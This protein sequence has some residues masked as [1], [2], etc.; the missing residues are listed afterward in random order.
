MNNRNG[1]R[2]TG[3]LLLRVMKKTAVVM[4]ILG[5]VIF[6][7]AGSLRYWNGWLYIGSLLFLMIPAMIYMCRHNPQ[8]I[9]KR[10]SINE[11]EKE[12]KVFV[13]LSVL[14]CFAS[15]AVPGL[16]Y[17]FG[18]S[19]VPFWLVM[20]SLLI[21]ISAYGMFFIVMQQNRY[22]SRVIEIQDN[23]TLIDTGLYSVIRH[24]MYS[25][26][27]LLYGVSPLVMGSY[28]A[29]I[30]LSFLPPL[31]VYRLINEEKFLMKELPGYKE[32]MTRVKYRL[33]PFIW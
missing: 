6:L 27:L 30:P 19:H 24:P 26:A 28:Y 29:L 25:S 16:D 13:K 20:V 32:Y 18:W 1:K 23:H 5:A 33:I 15:F 2:S 12:Q 7:P 3:K 4:I 17:R 8:L 31:V 9:E 22:A 11:K 14:L 21:M 10:L